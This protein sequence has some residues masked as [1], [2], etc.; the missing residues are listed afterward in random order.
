MAELVSSMKVY[1]MQGHGC[2]TGEVLT[3]PKGCMYVT[4]SYC[5]STMWLDNIAIINFAKLFNKTHKYHHWLQD[6]ITHLDNLR[7]VGLDIHIHYDAEGFDSTYTDCILCPFSGFSDK[8]AVSKDGHHV[9][10]SGIYRLGKDLTLDECPFPTDTIR[11]SPIKFIRCSSD[12]VDDEIL[13]FIFKD[14]IYPTIQQ[15]RHYLTM[16]ASPPTFKNLSV[17]GII[18]QS[19]LFDYY[20]GIHYNISCRTPCPGVLPKSLQLRRRHSYQQNV[21]ELL[22]PGFKPLSTYQLSHA[23]D[24][25]YERNGVGL[26]PIGTWDVSHITDMNEIFKNKLRFNEDI[27]DWDVSHVKTMVDTFTDAFS[28]KQSLAKWNPK[29]LIH[30]RISN[31]MISELFKLPPTLQLLSLANCPIRHLEFDTLHN[32]FDIKLHK[33][34]LDQDTLQRM[35]EVKLF[36]GKLKKRRSRISKTHRKHRKRHNLTTSN[37]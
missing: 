30:C 28:F 31:C 3:V 29:S 12:I 36:S 26:A 21:D 4:A 37:K 6:P 18:K 10:P 25:Y 16:S 14:S 34:S 5:G 35:V 11:N 2:D 27:S 33:V 17:M 22:F 7:S 20:K 8:N 1:S 15:V 9:I 24:L 23:I 13:E 32:R 19:S